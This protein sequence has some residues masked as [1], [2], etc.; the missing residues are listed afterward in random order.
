MRKT[1]III[2]VLVL[3]VSLMGYPQTANSA[4]NDE[5]ST[6]PSSFS[7]GEPSQLSVQLSTLTPTAQKMAETSKNKPKK[8]KK[9]K[10]KKPKPKKTKTAY[11]SP[12]DTARIIADAKAYGESIGMTWSDPLTKGNCSWEAPGATSP[13]LSGKRLKSAIRSSIRRIKKLQKDNGYR[14]GEFHFKVTFEPA[15]SGE[16]TIYFLMG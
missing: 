1:S 15:K 12:Y 7:A 2:A 13:T 3:T 6:A 16:Y 4:D 5:P 14:P 8:S 10:A 9:P 11:D